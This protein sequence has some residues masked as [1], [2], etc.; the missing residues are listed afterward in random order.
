MQ[1]AEKRSFIEEIKNQAKPRKNA[2]VRKIARVGIFT[3]E[4]AS[5]G[6]KPPFALT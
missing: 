4:Q 1:F 5:G 6:G 3:D 2:D